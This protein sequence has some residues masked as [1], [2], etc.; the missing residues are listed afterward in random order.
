MLRVSYGERGSQAAFQTVMLSLREG[1]NS[2]DECC[3]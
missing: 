1:F 2:Q 3:V